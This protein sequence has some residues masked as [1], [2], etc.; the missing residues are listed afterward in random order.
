MGLPEQGPLDKCH[1]LLFH[2]PQ[3]QT[4]WVMLI[5]LTTEVS[6]TTVFRNGDGESYELS[7]LREIEKPDL[8]PGK[9]PE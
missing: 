8:F 2:Y 3:Y 6:L 5:A 9:V 1:F 7:C 4:V